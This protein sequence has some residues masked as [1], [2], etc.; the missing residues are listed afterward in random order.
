MMFKNFKIKYKLLASFMLI[1]LLMGVVGYIGIN[2][3]AKVDSNTNGLYNKNYQSI[4]MLMDMKDNLSQIRADVLK[5]LYERDNPEQNKT[6]EQDIKANDDENSKY[7]SQYE[8]LPMNADEKREWTIF[9]NDY[10][11]YENL[12]SKLISLID[13]GKYDEALAVHPQYSD[14]RQKMSDSL[15]KI[16]Q[17]N[18]VDGETAYN[19][20]IFVYDNSRLI[21]IILMCLG[22]IVSIILGFILNKDIAVP[23]MLAVN[24]LKIVSNGDFTE[25]TP[26][27]YLKRKDEIG[28]M[29]NSIEAMQDNLTNLIKDIMDSSQNLSALSEELSSSVEEISARLES[30]SSSTSEIAGDVQ[31][32]SSSAEEIT[33]S[34]EE[35]TASIS[36]LSE[37]AIEGS[38]NAGNI[39]ERALNVQEE[40]KKSLNSTQQMY[41]EKQKAILQAIEDGKVVEKIKIMADTI[42]SIA[43]QTNLLALNAA[44]EAARAGEHGKGF[45][46][47][48]EEVRK[49]A[50]QSTQSVA[51]IQT[52]VKMVEGAFDNLSNYSS[53]ILKFIEENIEPHFNSFVEMGTQYY[54]DADFLSRMSEELASM[55]EE[56]NAAIEQ[57]SEAVQAMASTSQKVSENTNEIESSISDSSQGVEQ[58][59]KTA[60]EQAELAQ[61]LNEMIMKFKIS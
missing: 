57:V 29:I 39:K 43:S 9:K 61:K 59:A 26:E 21:M 56:I 17:S 40:G 48:A 33:A 19:N 27:R 30:I 18:L 34:V 10:V 42:A 3:L 4:Y 2:G 46:V 22:V 12:K 23:L 7:I 13:E 49:L 5:L 53:Q 36:Q 20:S 16:I 35:V 51:E 47:V 11:Q 6:L 38:N 58:V 55:T 24:H 37:R 44:I 15:D 31:D 28:D 45:A 41:K 60:Q 50:E 25:H 52:T 14:V 32:T 8:K 1:A 54:E